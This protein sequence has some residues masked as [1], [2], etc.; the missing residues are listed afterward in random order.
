MRLLSRTGV[1]GALAAAALVA[2]CGSDGDSAERSSAG[3]AGT[4]EAEGAD[5]NLVRD[6]ELTACVDPTY[7]PLEYFGT[8]K[9][10]TGYDIAMARA[11]SERLGVE[12]VFKQMAFSGILPALDAGR[13]DWTLAGTFVNPERT[14]RFIAVPYHNTTSVIMVKAGN[15]AGI[16]SP[17]DLAGKTVVTQNGTDL[18]KLAKKIS[19]DLEAKGQ[20]PANVQ[21]YEKFE[22]AIQQLVVGRADAVI[23]QDIDASY[24]DLRQPGTFEA[25]YSFPDKQV[26][27]TYFTQDN[28]ALADAVHEILEE[29]ESSGE[30][31]KLAEQE[32][33]PADG[34]AVEAP[35]TG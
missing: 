29:L 16:Q 26:F 28:E 8:N 1:A 14:A 17:D 15:P 35:I 6:G 24:R 10:Y 20:P 34:I 27:G 5:L 9:E 25:V 22:E 23:T 11:V 12:P 31:R 7:P 4:P 3:T 18:L 2:G 21:G 13:C 33:M 32:G 19:K 30:L